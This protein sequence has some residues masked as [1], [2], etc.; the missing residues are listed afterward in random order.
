MDEAGIRAAGRW[1]KQLQ[2][3]KARKVDFFNFSA[4]HSSQGSC[5]KDLCEFNRL[6]VAGS[7][8]IERNILP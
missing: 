5:V 1:Q 8:L 6:K 2:D 4:F 3:A 7:D